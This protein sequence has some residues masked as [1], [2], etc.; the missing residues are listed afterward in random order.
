MGALGIFRHAVHMLT[1]NLGTTFRI[2]TL[3]ILLS[4]IAFIVALGLCVGGF[5][6]LFDLISSGRQF[7]ISA[8]NWLPLVFF[9]V[10]SGL[11]WVWGAVGW[12]RYVILDEVPRGIAPKF[13]GN[14]IL[15][16]IWVIVLIS[17]LT[18]LLILIV[19]GLFG[20]VIPILPRF[21]VFAGAIV[22]GVV[23]ATVGLGL[24]AML[25][26]AAVKTDDSYSSVGFY[27][28]FEN[29]W[30]HLWTLVLL[31][32]FLTILIE[33]PNVIIG[34]LPVGIIQTSLSTLVKL[35]YLVLNI[36][37]MT[38]LYGIWFEDRKI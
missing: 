19:G 23:Q 8:V 11:L 4:M 28:V 13:I 24:S 17:I 22:W 21:V 7:D 6:T 9:C 5:T 32:V 34:L 33:V 12:H 30:E 27:D 16:Y 2:F 20:I 1:A 38:T 29:I 26:A 25:P 3:P 35:L 37:I 10:I 31:A 36:S 18:V 15:G 14:R